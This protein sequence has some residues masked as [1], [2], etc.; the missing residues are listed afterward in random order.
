M[1]AVGGLR[2]GFPSEAFGVAQAWIL[3]TDGAGPLY[4]PRSPISLRARA[5]RAAE[6]LRRVERLEN[7][8]R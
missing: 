4:N 3:L 8:S 6:S 1:R 7:A 2:L 5:V